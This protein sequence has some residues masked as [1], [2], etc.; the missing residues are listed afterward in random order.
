MDD[1]LTIILSKLDAIERLIANWGVSPPMQTI[2]P[3]SATWRITAT[4]EMAKEF[5]RQKRIARRRARCRQ[6]KK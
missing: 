6:T 4:E 2:S 5:S 1:K 3:G